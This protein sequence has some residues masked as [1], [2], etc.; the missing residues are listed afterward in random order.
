MF[1]S[2]LEFCNSKLNWCPSRFFTFKWRIHLRS[3]SVICSSFP[4]YTTCT[5][6]FLDGQVWHWPTGPKF[7]SYKGADNLNPQSLFFIQT[8]NPQQQ[9]QQQQ[10]LLNSIPR[11]MLLHLITYYTVQQAKII[12]Q[13]LGFVTL[14]FNW[15][16]FWAF[17]FKWR[18]AVQFCDSQQHICSVPRTATELKESST[19]H[20]HMIKSKLR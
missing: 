12:H 6:Q 3:S 19:Y 17:A 8:P 9:Q 15:R 2:C 18:P 13:C 11:R 7:G 10:L 20:K 16:H 5:S 4:S 1:H 14:K